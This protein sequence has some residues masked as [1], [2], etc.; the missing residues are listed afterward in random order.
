MPSR[1]LSCLVAFL[2]C[3]TTLFAQVKIELTV[4]LAQLE[5]NARVDSADANAHYELG[6][7]YWSHKRFDDAD[8]ALRRAL[9]IEPQFAAAYLALAY[10]PFARWPALFRQMQRDR[11]PEA[12][13]ATVEESERLRRRALMLDPLVDVSIIGAALRKTGAIPANA[14]SSRS[15]PLVAYIS[16]DYR[17]TFYLF[18]SIIDGARGAAR[19]SVPDALYWYRGFAAGHLGRY[20][21]AIADLNVLLQRAERLERSDNIQ[22]MAPRTNE[23]RYF[24]AFFHYKAQRFSRALQAY[25]EALAGDAGLYMAHVQ[26]GRIYQGH[27]MWDEA[28]MHFQQAAVAS[29]E[30]ASILVELGLAQWEFGQFAEAAAT[31]RQALELNPLDSRVLY[32]LGRLQL[33]R[34]DSAAA[35]EALTRFLSL[36]PRRLAEQADDA[37]LR[38]ARLP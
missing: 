11:V 31:F 30:D 17:T 22:V 10:L 27:K 21:V 23:F 6:L 33:T 38:L 18:G 28:V 20:D 3:G 36:A 4:S 19:D 13:K 35:R 8:R 12:S 2:A 24:I 1:V 15:D 14:R 16:G 32:F 34:N 9:A 25:L 26:M 29:P 5:S 37:R 7:G